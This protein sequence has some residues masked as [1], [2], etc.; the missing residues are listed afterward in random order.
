MKTTLIILLIISIFINFLNWL[1]KGWA[2]I[3][4]RHKKPL[5]WWYHKVMC[6]LYYRYKG[7]NDGYYKHL[8]IMVNI[9]NIN[10]YGE[11]SQPSQI[12]K[13]RTENKYNTFLK[14]L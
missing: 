1:K 13:E 11:A 8:I 2:P 10:L 9:Y 3:N 4:K 6:E 7:S 5:M 14:R 12:L